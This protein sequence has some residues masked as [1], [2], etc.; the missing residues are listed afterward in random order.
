LR[1]PGIEHHCHRG[2]VGN[3]FSEQFEPFPAQIRRNNAEPGGIPTWP[4]ETVHQTGSDRIADDCHDNRYRSGRAL[5]RLGSRRST[6]DDDFDIAPHELRGELRKPLD[7]I[8]SPFPLD[9][10]RLPLEIAEVSQSREE[11]FGAERK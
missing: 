6:R 3:D 9:L 11:C 8:L 1:V 7:S 10:D 5:E 4:R 2:Y